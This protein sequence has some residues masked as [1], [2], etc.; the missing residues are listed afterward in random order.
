MAS[1]LI[2][3][4]GFG[5]F[6]AFFCCPAIGADE[7]KSLLS[8][9][10]LAGWTIVNG[11]QDG[12]KN[13]HGILSCSGGGNGWILTDRE[14]ANFELELDFRVPKGGNSGIFLR[15]ARDGKPWVN[16]MEVQILDDYDSQ[17]ANLEPGQYTGS[18]YKVAPATPRVS[19]R[20]GEW[21][22]MQIF[23]DGAKLQVRLNGTQV[24]K[25]DLM[26]QS[27]R[28]PD[29]AGLKR[30]RG[31]LGLQNHNTPIEFRNLR[32]RQLP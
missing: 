1:R 8:D 13:L 14:Y 26:D 28:F 17:Y 4:F 7:W 12:W 32:I 27:K 25:T 24:V 21:Q 22:T 29:H 9:D 11:P 15:A 10:S 5:W 2:I 20:A 19:K 3:A 18:L 30:T 23:V 31:Y 16:G 6:V